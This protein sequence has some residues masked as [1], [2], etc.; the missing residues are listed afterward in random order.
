[1]LLY[2][3]CCMGGYFCVYVKHTRHNGHAIITPL[4]LAELYAI[5]FQSSYLSTTLCPGLTSWSLWI[6]SRKGDWFSYGKTCKTI[7]VN[8]FFIS[9]CLSFPLICLL[10]HV[11]LYPLWNRVRYSMWSQCDLF[12]LSNHVRSSNA[13]CWIKLSSTEGDHA[14]TCE[15]I[16]RSLPV[17]Q[18]AL[19][20]WN[21]F[22]VA[23]FE[24]LTWEPG[25]ETRIKI[26]VTT[27]QELLRVESALEP[28]TEASQKPPTLHCWKQGK[29]D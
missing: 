8:R 28:R 26:I 18:T 3:M 1:M 6:S 10:Y 16:W 25:K 11:P 24:L 27:S 9:R 15:T 2:I 14:Y 20:F 21:N 22:T 7:G 4:G 12:V 5:V 23:E 19:K 13:L 17:T 29:S